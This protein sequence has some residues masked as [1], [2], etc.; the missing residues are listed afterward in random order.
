MGWGRVAAV[1]GR[2]RRGLRLAELLS[3]VGRCQSSA[4]RGHK[5]RPGSKRI[6]AAKN[7]GKGEGEGRVNGVKGVEQTMQIGAISWAHFK[8]VTA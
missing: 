1:A 7:V 6:C 4:R 2:G 5:S 8:V 3:N